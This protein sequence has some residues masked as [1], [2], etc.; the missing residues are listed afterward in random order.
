MNDLSHS[1]VPPGGWRY[2][3]PQSKWSVPN[4]VSQT[5]G[6]AVQLIIKHR[7]ANPALV[8]KHGLKTD[9]ASVE[10]EL[11]SYRVRLKIRSIAPKTDARQHSLSL[12]AGAVADI[13]R[14]AQGTGVIIDWLTSGGQPVD[15]KP[16]TNALRYASNALRTSRVHGTPSHLLRSSVR[17]FQRGA[18]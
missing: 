12:V 8:L 18:T 4:P 10:Q 17:R 11:D 2:Y 5:F 1:Q 16:P 3:Q 15:Q 9:V 7:M 13:K 6:Q 14:A